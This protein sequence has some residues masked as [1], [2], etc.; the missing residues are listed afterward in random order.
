MDTPTSSHILLMDRIVLYESVT[1][2]PFSAGNKLI[3][4]T[5]QRVISDFTLGKSSEASADPLP[6]ENEEYNKISWTRSHSS[7]T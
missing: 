1:K 5:P 4:A 3:A 7:A 6:P 2:S